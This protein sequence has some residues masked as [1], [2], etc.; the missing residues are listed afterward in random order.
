MIWQ[1]LVIATCGFGLGFPIFLLWWSAV[2]PPRRNCVVMATLIAA[3]AATFVTLGMWLT[4]ASLSWQSL[5]WA[6]L[7]VGRRRYNK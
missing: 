4:V 6:A 3:M 5:T 2:K 7:L 1:D